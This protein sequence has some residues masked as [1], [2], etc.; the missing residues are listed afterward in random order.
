MFS[1]INEIYSEFD[2]SFT[3]TSEN[4]IFDEFRTAISIHIISPGFISLSPLFLSVEI[5]VL[6]V[7]KPPRY[8]NTPLLH[9]KDDVLNL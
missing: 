3:V 7:Y 8:S 1:P 4:R 5:L 2:S 9:F 6:S